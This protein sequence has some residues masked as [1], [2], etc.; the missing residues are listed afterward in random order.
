M[1]DF[2][3]GNGSTPKQEPLINTNRIL[4]SG[5]DMYFEIAS[6][7]KPIPEN[8]VEAWKNKLNFQANFTL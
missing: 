1:G 4:H 5:L 3:N 7:L 8:T 6:D 2:V